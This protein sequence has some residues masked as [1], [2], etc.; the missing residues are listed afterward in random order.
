MNTFTLQKKKLPI[1]NLNYIFFIPIAILSFFIPNI[2]ILKTI[3]PFIAVYLSVL[4]SKK[5]SYKFYIGSFFILLGIFFNNTNIVFTKNIFLFFLIQVLNLYIV[6]I[7]YSLKVFNRAVISSICLLVTNLVLIYFYKLGSFYLVNSLFEATLAFVL[8]LVLYR[9]ILNLDINKFD[10]FK[11]FS[12]NDIVSLTLFIGIILVG[13]EGFVIGSLNIQF[14]FFAFLS[15]IISYNFGSS[16]AMLVTFIFV[17]LTGLLTNIETISYGYTILLS[18]ILSGL[19]KNRALN[20]VGYVVGILFMYVYF[21]L[22]NIQAVPINILIINFSISGIVFYLLPDRLINLSYNSLKNTKEIKN[23]SI[24][25]KFNEQLQVFNRLTSIFESQY[26]SLKNSNINIDSCNSSLNLRLISA[27]Y[28]LYQQYI[29][30]KNNIENLIN[31]LNDKYEYKGHLE[32]KIKE[33]LKGNSV[34]IDS[35]SVFLNEKGKYEIYIKKHKLSVFAK[36]NVMINVIN[37]VMPVN[38]ILLKDID[39]TLYF[40]EKYKFSVIHSVATI[41]KGENDLSGDTFSIIQNS[42]GD[43]SFTLCDGMGSG[44]I[45]NKYST[46]TIELFEDLIKASFDKKSAIDILNSILLVREDGEFFSSLDCC[47]INRYTG[48]L[49]TYKLG[50]SSTYILRENKIE[51][52]TSKSLPIGILNDVEVD[53]SD[54]Q[55]QKGDIVIMM[56]DGVIDSNY[57]IKDKENYL[58]KKLSMCRK[59]TPQGIANYLVEETKKEYEGVALDDCTI[60]V[61]KIW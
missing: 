39:N 22:Y 17:F 33:H 7:N 10:D 36:N 32:R 56:T 50:A 35:I 53:T 30:F 34:L 40:I 28:L 49:K 11:R 29:Y 1:K 24:E 51:T 13:M 43:I 45:A 58:G 23:N 46:L 55:L 41:K 12:T 8:T 42:S 47:T 4:I 14:I 52:I 54:M 31:I 44:D 6:H 19:T 9:G 2:F 3:N 18:S 15:L 5:Y 21:Y 38:M 57:S 48:V 25:V 60:L 27:N 26:K 37:E 16:T 20:I 59:K 61:S